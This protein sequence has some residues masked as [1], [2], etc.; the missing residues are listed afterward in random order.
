MPSFHRAVLS[1]ASAALLLVAAPASIASADDCVPQTNV[2]P[3]A[4]VYG[5]AVV[6]DGDLYVTVREGFMIYEL[7]DPLSPEFVARIEVGE[8]KSNRHITTGGDLLIV[9]A[10]FEEDVF[11]ITNRSAPVLVDIWDGQSIASVIDDETDVV[12][13]IS[14]DAGDML[15]AAW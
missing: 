12:F 3:P 8:S 10:N 4:T 5:D 9:D 7:T 6:N 13:G 14:I 2:L 1:A 15:D 11:D